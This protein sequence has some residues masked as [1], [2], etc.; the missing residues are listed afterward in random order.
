LLLPRGINLDNVPRVKDGENGKAWLYAWDKEEEAAAFAK[1]LRQWTR[2]KKW[3]VRAVHGRPSRGP[4][5]PLQMDLTCHSGSWTFGLGSLT[6]W[7]LETRFPGSCPYASVDI[8]LRDED[9]HR[10]PTEDEVRNFAA[11][12]LF[13]VTGLSAEQLQVFEKFHVVDPVTLV[14]FL[15][16]TPIR[17]FSAGSVAS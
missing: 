3:H 17:A 2:D 9:Y 1:E 6:E 8:G 7:I 13:I 15:P 4:L 14:E 5:A 12:A 16:P 10:R 11:R